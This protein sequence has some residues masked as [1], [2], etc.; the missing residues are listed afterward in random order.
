M[1]RG[2]SKRTKKFLIYQ[3]ADLSIDN[4]EAL[5]A[6]NKEKKFLMKRHRRPGQVD[7]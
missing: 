2:G 4:R 6:H 5:T 3:F 1:F 7:R